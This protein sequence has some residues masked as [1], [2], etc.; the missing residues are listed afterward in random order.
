[1][2][3]ASSS[4]SAYGSAGG[5]A[6]GAA[7]FRLS[8]MMPLVGVVGGALKAYGSIQEGR[9]QSRALKAQ[10][11]AKLVEA[12]EVRKRGLW[13]QIRMNEDSRRLLSTQRQLYGQAGVT[14]EGAPMDLMR[15][16]E[17]QSVLDRMMHG[18][19]VAGEVSGLRTEAAELKKAARAA[20]RRGMIGAFSSFFS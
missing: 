19:N 1:M 20:R 17:E 11:Q 9:E 12:E 8:S 3:V 4:G 6:A 13:E 18:R 14:L 10:A 5:A 15:R 2:F 16:T 7:G